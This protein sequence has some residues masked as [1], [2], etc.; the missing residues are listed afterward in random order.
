MAMPAA[1]ASVPRAA[2]SS[3]CEGWPKMT[4]SP[5]IPSATPAIRKGVS[6][7]SPSQTVAMSPV[8]SGDKPKI[9]EIIPE[10][11]CRAPQ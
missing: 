8:T 7:R 6:E 1:T 2:R 3:P 11:M 5:P 10:G 9:T 4:H